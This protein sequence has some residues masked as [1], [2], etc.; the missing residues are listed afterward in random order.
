MFLDPQDDAG[1]VLVA[2]E[3]EA[4]DRINEERTSRGL[5][6]LTLR[7]DLTDVARA[8]SADMASRDFFS[9]DNPDGEGPFDRMASQGVA[10]T[11]A[12][13]NIAW[14]N[15]PDPV[16]IAVVGWMDSSGHRENILRERFTHT[17]MGIAS[18]GDGGYYFTQVF[19]GVSKNDVPDGEVQF[20]YH[21]AH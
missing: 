9:H 12:G 6:E 21:R 15:F 2:F 19:I 7:E 5:G 10:Y 16:D 1:S 18:D 13:E 17:G 11:I 3:A 14:N 20:F 4:H 8:H